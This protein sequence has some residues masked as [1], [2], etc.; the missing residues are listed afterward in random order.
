MKVKYV[1]S[2]SGL[3]YE[4]TIV[5][6]QVVSMKYL[7][8]DGQSWEKT[9]WLMSMNDLKDRTFCYPIQRS[10][11]QYFERNGYMFDIEALRQLFPIL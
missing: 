11:V 1:V 9:S 8:H 3:V 5:G 10:T 2:Q 6:R 4:V 7:N